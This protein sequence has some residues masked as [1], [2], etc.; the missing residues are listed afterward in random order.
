M[1]VFNIPRKRFDWLQFVSAVSRFALS[2][3][4]DEPFPLVEDGKVVFAADH[5][6]LTLP[7]GM[8]PEDIPAGPTERLDSGFDLYAPFAMFFDFGEFACA[9]GS[10]IEV[11]D[12]DDDESEDDDECPP[13]SDAQRRLISLEG[14]DLVFQTVL[15]SESDGDCEVE[16]VNEAGLLD[17]PMVKFIKSFMKQRAGRKA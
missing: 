14:A 5:E 6:E 17:G 9:D 3:G 4:A 8:E 11:P 10:I 15:M 16:D 7:D 12:L 2:K 1:S 13:L